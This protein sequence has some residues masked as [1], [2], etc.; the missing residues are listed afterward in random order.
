[1]LIELFAVGCVWGRWV[2]VTSS[3]VE[4]EVFWQ[5]GHVPRYR[6]SSIVMIKDTTVVGLY[7][8]IL[9]CVFV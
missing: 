1:M 8:C 7:V 3:R 5:V 4:V 6:S 9:Q 2:H